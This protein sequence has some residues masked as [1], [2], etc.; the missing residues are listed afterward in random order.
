MARAYDRQ[1]VRL[2]PCEQA[3][4]Y[5]GE[6]GVSRARVHEPK[7]SVRGYCISSL[8]VDGIETREI[9]G[10]QGSVFE[11]A[12]VVNSDCRFVHGFSILSLNRFFTISS[13]CRACSTYCRAAIDAASA[14][15]TRAFSKRMCSC[16]SEG[17][18]RFIHFSDLFAS[19][20]AFSC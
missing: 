16:A 12:K 19:A 9:D 15:S 3:L 13:S 6:I 20:I 5:A 14:A 18:A 1:T 4:K 11:S 7:G 17:S 2:R 10:F 8:L